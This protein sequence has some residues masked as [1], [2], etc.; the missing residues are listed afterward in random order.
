MRYGI[1]PKKF[2]IDVLIGK[3][4]PRFTPHF[5]NRDYMKLKGGCGTSSLA[6]L[7]GIT[8]KKIDEIAVK[9]DRDWWTDRDMLK[10]LN[11]NGYKTTELTISRVTNALFG[12]SSNTPIKYNHV[13][14]IGQYY[15]AN[16]GTWSVVNKN[17]IYH[18]FEAAPLNALEFINNPTMSVYIVEHK[19]WKE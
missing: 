7:T 19:K 15:Y 9:K 4:S 11:S 3:T 10:F 6:L 18:N 13:L 16:E 17:T 12:K 8:P 14:L 5:L 1:K 2:G